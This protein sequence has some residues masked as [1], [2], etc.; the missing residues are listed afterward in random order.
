MAREIVC[1]LTLLFE[2][3]FDWLQPIAA[4]WLRRLAPYPGMTRRFRSL[5]GLFLLSSVSVGRLTDIDNI[6]VN[7]DVSISYIVP[8]PQVWRIGEVAFAGPTV[9]EGLRINPLQDRSSDIRVSPRG[10]CGEISQRTGEARAT[11]TGFREK[12][13]RGA[14][15]LQTRSIIRAMSCRELPAIIVLWLAVASLI[16]RMTL[17]SLVPRKSIFSRGWSS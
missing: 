11:R 9:F 15:T 12:S 10:S 6:V 7:V 13:L 2:A 3:N 1:R 16:A 14:H 5:I 8:A 17:S 4:S